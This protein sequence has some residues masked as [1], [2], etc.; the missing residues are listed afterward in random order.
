MLAHGP[1]Q[2]SS[3]DEPFQL[4]LKTE[5]KGKCLLPFGL[6]FLQL[7]PSVGLVKPTHIGEDSLFF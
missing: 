1:A 3:Q 5:K 7:R 2:G 4:K 6:L